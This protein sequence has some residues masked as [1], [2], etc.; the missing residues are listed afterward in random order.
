MKHTG[1]IKLSKTI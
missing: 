1:I